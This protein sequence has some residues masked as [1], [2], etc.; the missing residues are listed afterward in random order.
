MSYVNPNAGEQLLVKIGD[1]GSPEV[2]TAPALINTTRSVKLSTTEVATEIPR[3][4][5]PSLPGYTARAITGIDWEVSGAGVLNVGDDKTY[6][7]WL[8]TGLPKN[9]QVVN[10]LTGGLT[11]QGSAV[12][13]DFQSSGSRGGKI[14]V[15]LTLKGAA[16]PA[17][18]TST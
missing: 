3:T 14:D 11:L 8:I 5:Q 4:D 12:L 16:L 10:N 17:T 18:S 6:A 1:G 13:T 2:F 9:I 7:D 15:T